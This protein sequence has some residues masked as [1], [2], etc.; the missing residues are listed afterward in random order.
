VIGKP[1]PDLGGILG[2]QRPFVDGIAA[3]RQSTAAL[4]SGMRYQLASAYDLALRG[5]LSGWTDGDSDG[6]RITTPRTREWAKAR[7]NVDG[8]AAGRVGI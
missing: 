4:V 1:N 5:S 2:G 7:V 6:V 3:L 8:R